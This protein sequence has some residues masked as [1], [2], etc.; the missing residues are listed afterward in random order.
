MLWER[1]GSGWATSAASDYDPVHV[2]EYYGGSA[3]DNQSLFAWDGT[4]LESLDIFEYVY[5]GAVAPREIVSVEQVA[6]T[7]TD[8]SP[9]ALPATVTVT[10]NDGTTEHPS[11]DMVGRGRLDPR[12][13]QLLDP[14]CHRHRPAGDR[15]GRRRGA[16]TSCGTPASKTPT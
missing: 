5:T 15:H 2:G 8:G 6:L 14:R 13:R 11:V 16:R 3:W 7:V 10:Y 1:D 4:P 12:T 9:V